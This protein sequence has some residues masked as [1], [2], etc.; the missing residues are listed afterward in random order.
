[1]WHSTESTT[2]Q[3]HSP[4]SQGDKGFRRVVIGAAR[5]DEAKQRQIQ[6]A[7]KNR[8]RVIAVET[9]RV[10]KDRMLEQITRERETELSRIAKEKEIEIEKKA[11]ADVIRG[12]IAVDKTVA[13]E[14]ERIKDTR[15]LAEAR[16][17]KDATVIAAEAKAWPSSRPRRS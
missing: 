2:E 10:E 6:V 17:N 15:V 14:E 12:R 16:R 8:E 3:C 9:E 4:Q 7:Q 13:E 1:M 11:I 5:G